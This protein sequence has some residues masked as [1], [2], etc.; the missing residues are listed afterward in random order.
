MRILALLLLVLAA[1]PP[2][3]APPGP[4]AAD[5]KPLA[6]DAPALPGDAMDQAC[7]NMLYKGCSGAAVNCS[8]TLHHVTDAGIVAGLSMAAIKCVAEAPSRAAI[9]ACSPFFTCPGE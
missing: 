1:C 8:A 6:Q 2:P 3:V 9:R 7:E 4:D 5:A